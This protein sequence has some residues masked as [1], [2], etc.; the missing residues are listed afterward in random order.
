MLSIQYKNTAV[1]S[2]I[3][4]QLFF[5]EYS[6]NYIIIRRLSWAHYRLMMYKC[7]ANNDASSHAN[8][9][10]QKVLD[11]AGKEKKIPKPF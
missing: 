1:Y 4:F 8:I 6:N 11:I 2:R 9:S 7:V 3:V 5:Q 10:S